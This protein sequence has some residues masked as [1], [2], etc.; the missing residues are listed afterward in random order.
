MKMQDAAEVTYIDK[1]RR[2]GKHSERRRQ[3]GW[4]ALLI[5]LP[6]FVS[7]GRAQ[8]SPKPTTPQSEAKR[9][10]EGMKSLAGSWRGTIMSLP[11]TFTIRAA[12]SGTAILHEGHT[13]AGAPPN[14]E[15]TM[16]YMEGERFLATHYCDAGNQSRFEVKMSADAKTIE[17]GFLDVTGSTR[18]GYLKGMVF[19]IVDA[20]HQTV[21]GTFVMP[22]GKT[23]PLRGDFQR[24]KQ[25]RQ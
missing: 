21:E 22:D 11:I 1:T 8:Q 4:V 5:C 23:V 19:T 14:H 10:F 6:I 2:I 17:L 20:N 3:K 13:E 15:I 24:D 16:F 25:L 18:G 9:A 7:A 12:S